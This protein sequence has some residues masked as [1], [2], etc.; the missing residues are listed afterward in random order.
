MK[1]T[2]LRGIMNQITPTPNAFALLLDEN[3]QIA[4]APQRAYDT[5]F[6]PG[7]AKC[8]ALQ[9]PAWVLTRRA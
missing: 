3:A 9:P 6:C 2:S 1:P 8:G 7:H 4:S 5:F